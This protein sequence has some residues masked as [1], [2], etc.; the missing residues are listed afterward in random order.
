MA[1]YLDERACNL[2]ARRAAR[3]R[4]TAIAVRVAAVPT[5]GAVHQL[6]VG[7]A[8]R[9]GYQQLPEVRRFGDVVLH[10]DAR[11]A[12]FSD[13]HDVTISAWRLGPIEQLVVVDEVRVLLDLLEWARTHPDPR[14][15]PRA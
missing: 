7:W 1:I 12:R 14:C 9:D 10:V 6:T 3:G 15:A 4:K 2:V 8:S 11:V 5:R 13:W